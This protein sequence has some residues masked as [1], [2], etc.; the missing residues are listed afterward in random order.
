MTGDSLIVQSAAYL[1]SMTAN[2]GDL[3]SLFAAAEQTIYAHFGTNGVIA[4]YVLSG[5]L[6]I[7]VLSKMIRL[8]LSALIYLVIPALVLAWVGSLLLP[9]SFTFLLPITA[10][11]CSLFFL[12]KS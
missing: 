3:K 7:A 6:G 12:F 8:A 10:A 2:S 11:G 9:Y 4:A 1:S 5:V